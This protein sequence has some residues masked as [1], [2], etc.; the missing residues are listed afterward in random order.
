MSLGS[1]LARGRQAAE[2]RMTDACTITRI[3]RGAMSSSGVIA[4]TSET[5]YSGKCRV[6][7]LDADASM[8]QAGGQQVVQQQLTLLVPVSFTTPLLPGDVATITASTFDPSLVGKTFRLRDIPYA[9]QS[10]AR[11]IRCEDEQT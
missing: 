3:T 6:K 1:T 7:T 4:E 9:S 10:T 8:A 5:I 11:R 2:S